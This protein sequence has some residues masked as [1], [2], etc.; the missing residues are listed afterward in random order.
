MVSATVANVNAIKIMRAQPASAGCLMRAVVPWRILCAMVEGSA[1]VIA[2]NV[3]R[4][5]S[6]HDV[7]PA[8]DALTLARPNCKEPK[9]LLNLFFQISPKCL[10]LK[11]K[12]VTLIK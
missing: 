4:D 12:I 8:L 1:S 11:K 6:V 9:V 7:R 2:V 5:T 3:M 10:L